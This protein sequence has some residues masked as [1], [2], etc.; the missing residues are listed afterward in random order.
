MDLCVSVCYLYDCISVAFDCCIEVLEICLIIESNL[1]VLS[2]LNYS[3]SIKKF[4]E[5]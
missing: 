5:Q 1:L 2:I 3:Y 4:L